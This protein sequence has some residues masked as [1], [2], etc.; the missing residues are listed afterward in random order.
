[1][2]LVEHDRPA[3]VEY[4]LASLRRLAA[5]GADIAAMA[6]NTPHAVFDDLVARSPI[7]I[8]SIVEA[9]AEEAQ[10]RDL[11]RLGLLGT[12][13]TMEGSFYPTVFARRGIA[14]VS[15]NNEER[16]WIH[17][18]YV[19]QLLKGEFRDETRDG[20]TKVIRRLRDEENVDGVI[21]GGTELTLLLS[22][23]VVG[24]VSALDTTALHVDAIVYRLR[25]LT[26]P[27]RTSR[28]ATFRRRLLRVHGAILTLVALGS[29]VATTIGW[30]TG[31]GLFGFMQRNP[32]V[33]VGL[34][35]A[36]LL[37][38]IIAVLLVIGSREANPRKWNVVGALAHCPPLIAALSSLQVFASMGALGL[39]R[40]AIA[41][42][43]V[44]L[45][46][47]MFA[48]LYPNR[49][50]PDLQEPE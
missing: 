7:P 19:G 10:R 1:L 38:T 22:G 37:M 16:A 9:C 2:R 47:E 41:F 5:A 12:R 39:V 13:F 18:C 31:S 17:D 32:L 23:P 50:T 20:V 34:I 30:M 28:I 26:T 36:Y 48:A 11:R 40:V 46:L 27:Q 33:W 8:V 44:W 49:R 35:Q 25:L 3:L 42:H 43:V 21:L 14:I 6:A 29:A 24:G 15:P 45:S 4:L